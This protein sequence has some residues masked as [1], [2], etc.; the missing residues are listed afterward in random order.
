MSCYSPF[1]VSASRLKPA[2]YPP[3]LRDG[4][5]ESSTTPEILFRTFDCYRSR[6]F[7]YARMDYGTSSR[8]KVFWEKGGKETLI[9]NDQ[10]KQRENSWG[11]EEKYL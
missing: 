8:Y 9:Q 1:R 5:W 6:R 10:K 11:Q 4:L 3:A 7:F 2:A